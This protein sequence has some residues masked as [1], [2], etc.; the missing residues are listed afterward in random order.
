MSTKKDRAVVR[1]YENVFDWF[2]DHYGNGPDSW[3]AIDL[4]VGRYLVLKL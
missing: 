4:A 2:A 3:L 1:D